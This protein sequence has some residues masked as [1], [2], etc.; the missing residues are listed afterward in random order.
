MMGVATVSHGEHK[1]NFTTFYY[2]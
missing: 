2:F 1:D